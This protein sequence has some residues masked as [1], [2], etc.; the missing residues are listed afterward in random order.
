LPGEKTLLHLNLEWSIEIEKI[1]GSQLLIFK[2]AEPI[3]H[4]GTKKGKKK[5]FSA[6]N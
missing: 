3:R 6:K 4:S 2:D 5:T 1:Q